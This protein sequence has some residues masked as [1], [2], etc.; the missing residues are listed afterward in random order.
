MKTQAW[1]W[2]T[3]AVLAAGL[4]ASYHDGG[5]EWAHHVVGKVGHNAAAV[6]ALASGN[7]GQFLTE[8]RV[9]AAHT[10]GRP[11]RLSTAISRMESQIEASDAEIDRVQAMSD[12]E[13]A[14]WN[15]L[16][17]SRERIEAAVAI[18]QAR[19]HVAMAG[20]NPAEFSAL[21]FRPCPRV[22]VSVPKI[23]MV[24]AP[25]VRVTM[26]GAGPV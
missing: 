25:V 6:L 3:A 1:G 9:I 14:Q 20:F 18:E 13:M 21:K 26:P 10:E 17:A 23:P 11:C 19:V 2:L 8:A 5:L 24:K 15:R 4:N 16:Q 7:A 22:R 12:R